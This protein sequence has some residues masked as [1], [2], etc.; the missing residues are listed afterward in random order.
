MLKALVGDESQIVREFLID[1]RDTLALVA[2]ELHAALAANDI[3]KISAIAHRLK[4]ASR[5]VGALALGD[6]CAELENAC[7]TSTIEGL[8][9]R[10]TAFETELRVV[11]TLLHGL[12]LHDGGA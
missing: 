12:L 1:F 5:T 10:M 7:R 4:S 6:K 3:Q 2:P 9:Q 11:E 8:S